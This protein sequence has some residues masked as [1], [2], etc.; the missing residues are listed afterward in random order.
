M[1]K[2]TNA[3]WCLHSEKRKHIAFCGV[4]PQSNKPAGLP[5]S[6]FVKTSEAHL[7]YEKKIQTWLDSIGSLCAFHS[8]KESWAPRWAPIIGADLPCRHVRNITR[9][10]DFV[11]REGPFSCQRGL[12]CGGGCNWNTPAICRHCATPSIWEYFLFCCSNI[13]AEEIHLSWFYDTF[14][15]NLQGVTLNAL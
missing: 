15:V 3:S 11:L 8:N 13:K 9:Q 12:N 4:T 14:F 7:C 5:I 1:G 2:N 6:L 10:T